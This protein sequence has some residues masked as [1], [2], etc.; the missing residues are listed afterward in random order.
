M[1]PI[2]IAEESKVSF[3][4]KTFVSV[5]A[6]TAIAVSGYLQ[7]THRITVLERIMT[8]VEKNEEWINSFEPPKSVQETVTHVRELELQV[9]RL[10]VLIENL[11]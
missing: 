4:L 5:L 6:L 11:R 1:E 3:P 9:A 7:L 8:Q 2:N 10:E